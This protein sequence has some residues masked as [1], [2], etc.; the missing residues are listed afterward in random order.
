M[1]WFFHVLIGE[2]QVFEDSLYVAL[3]P[4]GKPGEIGKY[5]KYHWKPCQN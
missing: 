3:G 2:D 4:Y 5:E 1:M